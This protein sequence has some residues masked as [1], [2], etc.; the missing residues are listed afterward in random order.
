[1]GGAKEVGLQL[2]ATEGFCCEPSRLAIGNIGNGGAVG[3]PMVVGFV[4]ITFGVHAQLFADVDVFA[5]GKGE[6]LL[7]DV[8]IVGSEG[9][10]GE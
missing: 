1:M 10:F 2:L 9:A 3:G 6:S 4:K 5:R 8:I 7:V